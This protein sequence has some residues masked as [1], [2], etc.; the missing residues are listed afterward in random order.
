MKTNRVNAIA[1]DKRAAIID[2]V[3]HTARTLKCKDTLVSLILDLETKFNRT[4]LSYASQR[5]HAEVVDMIITALLI[6][7]GSLQTPRSI[8]ALNP[9]ALRRNKT[10]HSIITKLDQNGRSALSYAAENG[11]V[12]ILELLLYCG[13]K[14]ET[15]EERVLSRAPL[16]YAA[17]NGHTEIV[18]MLIKKGARPA[19]QDSQCRQPI[20]LAVQAGHRD[21]VKVLLEEAKTGCVLRNEQGDTPLEIAADNKDKEMVQL[22]LDNRARFNKDDRKRLLQ[23]GIKVQLKSNGQRMVKD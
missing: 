10:L 12:A 1:A 16:S 21:V 5:G 19:G 17:E 4:P 11:H 14:S 3:L 22:L 8:H 15:Y 18:R 13:A 6:R 23:S 9:R 7:L 20:H 2:N